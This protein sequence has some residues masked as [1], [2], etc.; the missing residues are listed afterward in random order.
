MTSISMRHKFKNLMFVSTFQ[1]IYGLEEFGLR[2]NK[3]DTQI[4]TQK[5]IDTHA[6]FNDGYNWKSHKAVTLYS[7]H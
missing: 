7:S 3:D 6:H 1:S 2:F 4:T 5:Q